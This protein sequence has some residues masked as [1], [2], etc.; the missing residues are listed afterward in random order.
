MK[1][2]FSLAHLTLLQCNPPDLIEVAA[3]AGFDYVS[4]RAI[5]VTPNEPKYPF[6]EDKNLLK[7]TKT[8]LAETGL[9]LL[10]IELARILANVDPKVYVPAFEA[11]AELGGKHVLSSGWTPDRTYVSEKF[12]ELCELAEPF[13]LTVDFEFV[14]FAAMGTL[15]DAASVVKGAGRENGGICIDTL[16]FF[17]SNT[18][19]SE[20][21]SLP[22]T[23]FR[24]MQLCDAPKEAPATVDELIF[25]ARADRKFLGEGGLDLASVINRLQVMPYSLE[26]PN[27]RLALTTSPLEFARKA[28]ETAK[29]YLDSIRHTPVASRA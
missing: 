5:P 21:D 27:A 11:A 9:K 26:I 7:R 4:L 10:D 15:A 18:L 1:H 3:R 23:W 14:T 17:R 6:G 28:L 12:A 24:F 13:G 2:E 16:H 20:L 19:L 25:A 29:A 8:A 22:K